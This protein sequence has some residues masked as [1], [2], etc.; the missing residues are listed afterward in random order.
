MLTNYPATNV[1]VA[2]SFF[3]D[4]G[5][6]LHRY[7]KTIDTFF[8]IKSRRLK[9]FNDLR[10]A[11]EC[12]LKCAI[13]Y[14]QQSTTERRLLIEATERHGHHIDRLEDDVTRLIGDNPYGVESKGALFGRLPVSLRYSLDGFDF[15]K[16][17]EQLYYATIGSDNWLY[18][19]RSYI[20]R[21]YEA[22]NDTLSKH[23]GIISAAD[24]PS[25]K[26]LG[27]EYCKYRKA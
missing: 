24:I 19:L 2:Q 22:L 10:G 16:A 27:S 20:G 12:A 21:I 4:C 14:H 1:E 18:S 3:L 7:D 17:Q 23:S 9:C 8:A 6:L 11:Y 15:L 25:E 13:A 26:L 5:D